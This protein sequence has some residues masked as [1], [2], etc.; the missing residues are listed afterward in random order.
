MTPLFRKDRVEPPEREE[1]RGKPGRSEQPPKGAFFLAGPP[2]AP[3]E[4]VT[5]P[6]E[7]EALTELAL[8]QMA[9]RPGLAGN[10]EEHVIRRIDPA[11]AE[12]MRD[13]AMREFMER[14]AELERKEKGPDDG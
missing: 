12:A 3:A 7:E 8:E 14:K 1:E 13:R 4:R 6:E 9:G 10:P 11:S 5:P 2:G